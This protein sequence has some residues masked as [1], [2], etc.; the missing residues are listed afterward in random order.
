MILASRSRATVWGTLSFGFFL[1]VIGVFSGLA[2]AVVGPI[3][4]AV[5]AIVALGAAAFFLPLPWLVITLFAASFLVTGQLI[6]FGQQDRALWL[7]FLLGALILVRYPFD[8]MLRGR[9]AIG[10]S[11]AARA[12]GLSL[13]GLCLL[14]Y[15]AVAVG[16]TL[17]N[18]VA[19]LQIFVSS[20][21]YIFLWGVYLVMGTGLV[22][23]DLASRIWAWLPWLMV[24]QLPLVFYQRF[25]VAPSRAARHVGAEWD[26]IVGAF[27]GNPEGGGASGAMGVFCVVAMAF[28]A[29]RWRRGHLSSFQAAILMISGLLSIALAE[30]KFAVLLLPIAFGMAF[31]RDIVQRPLRGVV[32]IFVALV[33]SAIVLF[34]YKLQYSTSQFKDESI[35]EYFNSMF[36]SSSDPNFVNMRTREIGRTAAIK[37]WWQQ[38]GIDNPTQLLIG[39]GIGASRVGSM[40]VGDAARPWPFNIGRSSLAVLLW[41]TGLLGTTALVLALLLAC[42]RSFVLA[43]VVRVSPVDQTLCAGSGVVCV[44]V[45]CGLVYNTD[46]MQTHQTQLLLMLALGTLTRVR[47]EVLGGAVTRQSSAA[48]AAM[49]GLPA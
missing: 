21:E 48:Q 26:A 19:P 14:V 12:D 8:R 30:I 38:H 7:P 25:V 17:I 3:A 42:Q 39:H 24:V 33:L 29:L 13:L 23:P 27:G 10:L 6:Y 5:L 1:L 2:I 22:A 37:F 49:R 44:A 32:G 18:I 31:L 36:T 46:F 11:V 16:A 4:A 47:L 35:S 45:L 15:F 20:K 28:V 40:V 34:S 9:Q 41:E 43:N